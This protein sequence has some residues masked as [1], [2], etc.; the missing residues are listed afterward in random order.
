M[1]RRVRVVAGEDVTAMKRNGAL[2]LPD[3]AKGK[4]RRRRQPE[5]KR[6]KPIRAVEESGD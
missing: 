6:P 1:L 5:S 4:L 3:D 2:M